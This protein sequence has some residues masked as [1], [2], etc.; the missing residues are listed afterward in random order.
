[1]FTPREAF[2]SEEI[3]DNEIDEDDSCYVT[4]T[5]P[6]KPKPKNTHEWRQLV[7][8]ASIEDT[9]KLSKGYSWLYPEAR[10]KTYCKITIKRF[11][12]ICIILL[13]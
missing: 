3:D 11:L 7:A 4:F 12:F 8:A 13:N 1:M 9:K 2:L 10:N 5:P 6:Q